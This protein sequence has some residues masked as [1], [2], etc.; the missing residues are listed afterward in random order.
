MAMAAEMV[1]LEETVKIVRKMNGVNL[2]KS[3]VEHTLMN[4]FGLFTQHD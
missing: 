2:A 4:T 3:V 1:V